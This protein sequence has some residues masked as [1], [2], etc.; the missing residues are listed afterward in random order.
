MNTRHS[1]IRGTVVAFATVRAMLAALGVAAA[2]ILSGTAASATVYSDV[3]HT[4]DKC[5][6][7]DS[8]VPANSM[9]IYFPNGG[10]ENVYVNTCIGYHMITGAYKFFITVTWSD[11]DNNRPSVPYDHFKIH[12]QEQD[13]DTDIGTKDCDI[14]SQMNASGTSGSATCVVNPVYYLPSALTTDGWV[15]W[16]INNDGVGYQP[17]HNVT[18]SPNYAANEFKHYVEEGS[19]CTIVTEKPKK[20][21]DGYVYFRGGV[22]CPNN[23]M[24]FDA[25]GSVEAYQAASTTGTATRE[26]HAEYDC[27]QS[28]SPWYA[29]VAETKVLD[30]SGTQYWKTLMEG[31][32]GGWTG[33]NRTG[34][35]Y[36]PDPTLHPGGTTSAWITS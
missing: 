17:Q 30:P 23:G 6:G 21:H 24:T 36:F 27:Y 10:N 35:A 9:L 15:Q 32:V 1:S 14:T 11:S 22:A 3:D 8:G 34:G 13:S 18:G 2:V 31:N 5:S 19:G 33:G 7:T 28:G 12:L 20:Y 25:H 4:M 26:N 29:C 16:D